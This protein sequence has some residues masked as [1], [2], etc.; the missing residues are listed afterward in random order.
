MS[1]LFRFKTVYYFCRFIRILTTDVFSIFSIFPAILWIAG[2]YFLY[3]KE[4]TVG[5]F[6]SLFKDLSQL[7]VFILAFYIWVLWNVILATYKTFVM[8]TGKW[9]QNRFIFD[10]PI[11]VFTTLVRP[12]DDGKYIEYKIPDVQ[13]GATVGIQIECYGG[14]AKVTH[15]L[16]QPISTFA[17]RSVQGSFLLSK[18]G[19][20]KLAVHCPENSDP[21]IVRVYMVYWQV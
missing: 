6:T 9:F 3:D 16:V 12:E 11:P 14:I 4:G 15:M 19:K 8:G 20:S 1:K 21:T 7:K 10:T 18:G 17:Q 13:S 2:Y 5:V